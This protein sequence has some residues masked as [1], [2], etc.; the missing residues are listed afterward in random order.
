MIETPTKKADESHVESA[1][2]VPL[3]T[4]A[5]AERELERLA[6]L[7]KIEY[8][9]ARKDAA[10]RLGMRTSALD[11]VV[12][13]LRPAE[14]GGA[15]GKPLD[16]PT[17]EPWEHPV[18]GAT[19]LDELVAAIRRYVV[20]DDGAA[21]A[22][23]LWVIHSHALDAF[24]I[25]PRLSITSPEKQ[26]G[27]STLLDV[28]SK[29]VPRPLSTSNVTA[30][31]I[32]RTVEAARPTLLIDEAD[33]FLK[34]DADELRGI[35]N[36]GHRRNGAVTRLVGDDHEPRQFSTWAATALAAIGRLPD[37]LDDRSVTIRLR[38]RRPDEAAD[39]L[40]IDRTPQLDRLARM[41]ARWTVDTIETL[42]DADPDLPD[43][44]NNRVADNWR[45]MVA[46]ADAAG[47][48][49][50]A[51]AHR[52]AE[53]V[54]LNRDGQQS[55]RVMLLEDIRAA[56]ET[57][58]TD[59]LSSAELVAFLVELEGRPWAEWRHGKPLTVNKLAR[60]LGPF[61]ISP[62]TVRLDDGRILK[63]YQRGDF[64]D[65]FL[66]YT[67]PVQNVT[68]LQPADLLACNVSQSVTSL[69]DVTLSKPL[70]AKESATCNAV[71]VS[72][73]GCDTDDEFKVDL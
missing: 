2:L 63:G 27:K 4:Q 47:G 43:V 67:P 10:K 28:I 19:L 17:P 9:Q 5:D 62:T 34:Q 22:V 32:F 55:A 48:E 45:P 57:R 71:T 35:L 70:Q 65:A 64:A 37:T 3:P 29:L 12:R 11:A 54:A 49:W 31:A 41:A 13:K 8:E 1:E 56:F 59:R 42:R 46:I 53:A 33:T 69:S 14:N 52:I 26:C 30:A 73:G 61:G 18:D 39:P 7:S 21:D 66:R 44:L 36:S 23:A 50:P 16:L 6:G 25:S 68:P 38:R 15:K 24:V 72:K 40:R 58:G 20:L 60:L 51:R